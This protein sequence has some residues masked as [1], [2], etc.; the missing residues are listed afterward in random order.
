MVS[1][2]RSLP[3][4][5]QTS[6]VAS[7][8]MV[9]P[10]PVIRGSREARGKITG[11]R[12]G[13]AGCPRGDPSPGRCRG[14]ADLCQGG[15][16]AVVE[17]AEVLGVIRYELQYVLLGDREQVAVWRCVSLADEEDVC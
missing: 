9:A 8:G 13:W 10:F 7:A 3:Q 17:G 15:R 4:A 16:D 11:P 2:S 12:G 5:V 1:N 6:S 14:S